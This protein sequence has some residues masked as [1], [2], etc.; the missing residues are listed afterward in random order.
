MNLMLRQR[1]NNLTAPLAPGNR[2]RSRLAA[3]VASI[4]FDDFPRSAWTVGGPILA[5]Y[6]AKATYYAAGRYC[7]VV[8][9]GLAYYTA[10]DLRAVQAAGHE[11]GCHSY[12]HTFVSRAGAAALKHDLAANQQAVSAVLGDVRLSS[13]AYP[14]GDTSIRTK[15]LFA[16]LFPTSRGIHPGSTRA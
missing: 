3:P 6:G 4:T 1:F 7:G 5:R 15:R 12:G 11:V 13:F 9:E 8:E 14:Y 16:E 10:D 2:V